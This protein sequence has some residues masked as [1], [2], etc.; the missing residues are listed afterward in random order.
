MLTPACITTYE[1]GQEFESTTCST[2][3]R[4]MSEILLPVVEAQVLPCSSLLSALS[5]R[6]DDNSDSLMRWYE[7]VSNGDC[8]GAAALPQA[9]PIAAVCRVVL[10]RSIESE[11]DRVTQSNGKLGHPSPLRCPDGIV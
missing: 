3:A 1:V 10:C 6:L 9:N 7:A 11:W 5:L 4:D 8:D 2:D